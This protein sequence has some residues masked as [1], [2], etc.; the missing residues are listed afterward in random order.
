VPD[1]G[2]GLTAPARIVLSIES[3]RP[4]KPIFF[5]SATEFRRW[6]EKHHDTAREIWVGFYRK[7]SGRRG[8]AYAD[9]VDQA[10]CYGWI[11]GIR[12]E[13]MKKDTRTVFRHAR[14]RASGAPSISNAL[15]S[16]DASV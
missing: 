3:L 16:S 1:Q 15:R 6:L 11:D 5:R 13:S 9:A 8:I 12:S 14:R 4:M 7:D 10:L 2:Q